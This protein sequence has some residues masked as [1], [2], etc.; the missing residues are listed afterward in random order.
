MKICL[1][2][3]GGNLLL[4]KSLLTNIPSLTLMCRSKN[5]ACVPLCSNF[6]SNSPGYVHL[7][8]FEVHYRVTPI[9]E[10]TAE[11]TSLK[12]NL[13]NHPDKKPFAHHLVSPPSD[14]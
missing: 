7:K 13:A 2:Y 1:F 6:S 14:F 5:V 11:I 8:D 4:S 9:G 3:Q 12:E 10:G